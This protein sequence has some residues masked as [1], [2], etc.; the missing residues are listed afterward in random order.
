MNQMLPGLP[1]DDGGEARVSYAPRRRIPLI[2]VRAAVLVLDM[3]GAII[4]SALIFRGYG[5][6]RELPVEQIYFGLSI[7]MVAWL[8]A[9]EAQSLYGEEAT[10]NARLGLGAALRTWLLAFG[11]V[12]LVAFGLNLIAGFSRVWLFAWALSVAL[13]VGVVRLVWDEV[14]QRM[15]AATYCL[16]RVVII[17]RNRQEAQRLARQIEHGSK[18]QS[19]V[20]GLQVL[21]EVDVAAIEAMAREGRLEHVILAEDPA[22]LPAMQA[23]L[24]RL[25]RVVVRASVVREQE[26]LVSASTRFERV[27]GVPALVVSDQPMRG[28]DV[29][30]KRAEDMVL[31]CCVLLALAPLLLLVAIAIRLDSPGPVFFRQPRAGF[32]G[33]TFSIWKFRTMHDAARDEGARRQTSRWDPRVTRVGRFLRR[34]SIDELPQLINV[35]M[36]QM[37]LVG[38]RPHALGMRTLGMELDQLVEDYAARHRIKPG[39][40]GWAQVNGLRGEVSSIEQL[41]Q[42]VEYDL[43]YIENWS[44]AF[45][46]WILLRTIRIVLY[47]DRAY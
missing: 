26:W 2:W 46:L 17:A 14:M 42:R 11:L 1:P 43:A 8:L 35:I 40:T 32:R 9:A 13:W 3:A 5:D 21:A 45:D 23:L 25:R 28:I 39:M 38:P 20:V 33:Q 18:G 37:S 6:V 31:A 19:R 30:T 41:R 12:L 27:G 24:G 15:L 10:T 47:D 7:Y 44:L 4:L 22:Q 29:F 36:G 34:T 16:E